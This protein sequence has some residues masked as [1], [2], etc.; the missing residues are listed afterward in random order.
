[1]FVHNWSWNPTTV[2]VPVAVRHLLGGG[3]TPTGGQLHLGAWD[4][5]ILTE[6]DAR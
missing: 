1:V 6:D 5:A 4:V 3:S 2:I